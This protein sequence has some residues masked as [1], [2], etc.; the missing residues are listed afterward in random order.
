MIGNDSEFGKW[1]PVGHEVEAGKSVAWVWAYRALVNMTVWVM[2][3]FE[4]PQSYLP[5][6]AVRSDDIDDAD[7][8]RSSGLLSLFGS[9]ACGDGS[10]G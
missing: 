2:T 4:V 6:P 1:F 9:L 8:L 3:W 10:V 7:G 5:P